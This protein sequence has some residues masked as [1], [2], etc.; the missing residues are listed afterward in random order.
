MMRVRKFNCPS[1]IPLINVLS[2]SALPSSSSFRAWPAEDN[3]MARVAYSSVVPNLS[4]LFRVTVRHPLSRVRKRIM[5]HCRIH[6]HNNI[7]LFYSVI[8]HILCKAPY[9]LILVGLSLLVSRNFPGVIL[10][11]HCAL[12]LVSQCQSRPEPRSLSWL[13][14]IVPLTCFLSGRFYDCMSV[15]PVWPLP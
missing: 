14:H 13:F 9:I 5:W 4:S 15:S 3:L 7:M 6:F 8:F 12:F 10:I 1:L 2:C 11:L